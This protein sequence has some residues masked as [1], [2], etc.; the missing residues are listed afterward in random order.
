M[1][2]NGRIFFGLLLVFFGIFLEL[3][4][5]SFIQF[6][7]AEYKELSLKVIVSQNNNARVVEEINPRTIVS[8]INI[9]A[10]SS[11]ISH[12]L[13]TDEKNIVLATSQKANAIRIDTLGASHVV[14]TY[15]AIN[16]INKTA[17][18]W[19]LNY[20]GSNLDST[21]VLPPVSDII[22]VSNVPIDI[23]G[24]TITMPAGQVSISYI[25][26]TVT[27]DNFPVSWNGLIYQVQIITAS[28][29]QRFNFDH[30]SKSITMTLDSQAPVL[31]IL[32]KSLIG[33]PY[34]VSL[35]G[36]PIEFKEYYQN[37]TH[38][39][40]RVDPT[41]SGTLTITGK[42]VAV[43]E[44]PSAQSFIFVIAL[45]IVTSIIIAN[46]RALIKNLG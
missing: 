28:T 42:T 15:D 26:R 21:I 8:S 12:I 40:M 18:V 2:R 20:D 32:P 33:G 22:S 23:K 27:K 11:N 7:Y 30:N 10:I 37:A 38:S 16:V 29:L 34:V 46:K 43:P 19:N 44:F 6:V 5:F 24:N 41:G 9:Q 31:A 45:L 14:L 13:A 17:G 39:W 4:T 1:N 25:V 36:I 35:N 3:E